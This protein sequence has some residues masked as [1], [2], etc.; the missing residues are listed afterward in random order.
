MAFPNFS[1]T[2]DLQSTI[3][4]CQRLLYCVYYIKYYVWLRFTCT[5]VCTLLTNNILLAG[6]LFTTSILL[7]QSISGRL[8]CISLARVLLTDSVPKQKLYTKQPV[9]VCHN[10]TFVVHK[11]FML[12]KM[13][14][15][16]ERDCL[17]LMPVSVHTNSQTNINFFG[18]Q[19]R[20]VTLIISRLHKSTITILALQ[21]FNALS[22][23]LMVCFCTHTHVH[24]HILSYLPSVPVWPGQ[25]RNLGPCPGWHKILLMSWNFHEFKP[26]AA[27]LEL[28]VQMIPSVVQGEPCRSARSNFRH[29]ELD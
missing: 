24:V 21:T 10:A 1:V 11:T 18:E 9:R 14:S 16:F 19:T 15:G 17:L 25:S 27:N 12:M 23:Q 8:K 6:L 5:A 13:E 26:W 3:T 22:L 2:T 20:A 7:C 28:G 4:Y 29:I